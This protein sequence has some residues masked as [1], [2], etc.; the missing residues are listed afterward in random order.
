MLVNASYAQDIAYET[1]ITALCPNTE[2]EFSAWIYNIYPTGSIKPDLTFVIDGIGR[3]TTGDITTSGWQN[4]GFR[5][6]TGSS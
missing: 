5:F 1:D 4:I 2:Y 3:Y 6:E